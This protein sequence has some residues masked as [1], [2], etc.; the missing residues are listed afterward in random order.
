MLQKYLFFYRLCDVHHIY[1]DQVCFILSVYEEKGEI[2]MVGCMNM[3]PNIELCPGLQQL[4]DEHVPLL[5]MLHELRAVGTS[6]AKQET[7][8]DAEFNTATEKLQLF[9]SEL[10]PH[11]EKEENILFQMMGKYLP[12]T[13]GPI[14]VMEEEHNQ[15]KGLINRYF[16]VV[17]DA[18]ENFSQDMKKQL[19][20]SLGIVHTILTEHF[21]KEENV[22]FPM[23]ANMLSDEEKQILNEKLIP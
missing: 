15:A 10:E 4:K 8:T 5:E 14:Q 11:S 1:D 23:A 12:P 16:E 7:I 22:L 6:L 18:K 17:H 19:A 13:G 21:A 9:F 2:I 3:N 20:G